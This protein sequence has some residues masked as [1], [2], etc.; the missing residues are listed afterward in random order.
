MCLGE[1]MTQITIYRTRRFNHQI[2]RTHISLD[3]YKSGKSKKK[4]K[5]LINF[6]FAIYI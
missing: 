4:K 5:H 6:S 3:E 2:R 1:Y